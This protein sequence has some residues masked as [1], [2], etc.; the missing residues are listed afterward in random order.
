MGAFIDSNI[1]NHRKKPNSVQNL[2]V[3]SPLCALL[4]SDN[5]LNLAMRL[6]KKLEQLRTKRGQL[7][8]CHQKLLS[9][10][11][12]GAS[13]N[14]SK[15]EEVE[16]TVLLLRLCASMI[17]QINSR[18]EISVNYYYDASI[19]DNSCLYCLNV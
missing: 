11:I 19:L 8:E 3:L 13:A 12:T 16:K 7:T 5:K 1:T 10:L 14:L 4:D 18:K 2:E 9:H 15:S 6:V 17:C